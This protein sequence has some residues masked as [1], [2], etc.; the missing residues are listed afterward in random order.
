MAS[1]REWAASHGVCVDDV[2]P[3]V[4]D[5][6]EPCRRTS[7]EVAVRTIILHCVAGVGYG[8]DPCPV[9]DWLKDENLWDHVSAD[10]QAF[11]RAESPSA[12]VLSDARW[13]Q[14]AEWALLWTIRKVESLGL[15]T[16]T[17]DTQRLVDEIMPGLGDSISSFVS[18]AELRPPSELLTED[19]RIYNLHGF[20]R[21]AH[22]QDSLPDDLVY[23]ILFQRHYAFEWL[24][25]DDD[26]DDV[27]TDT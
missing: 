17:C 24:S 16:Q 6:N 14:E 23:D 18:S 3:P 27:R 12:K 10:E 22:R 11:L 7:E 25:G 21:Q 13:R 26:W 15:P 20:A 8:V 19:D 2:V 9:I 4:D 1:T 5:W